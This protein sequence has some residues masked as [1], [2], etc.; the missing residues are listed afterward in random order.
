MSLLQHDPGVANAPATVTVPD[1]TTP[2]ILSIVSSYDG[3]GAGGVTVE[4][5]GVE[6][7]HYAVISGGPTQVRFSSWSERAPVVVTLLAV[8]GTKGTIAVEFE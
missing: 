8:L 3:A 4:V 2:K 5:D 6:V 1:R 7:L